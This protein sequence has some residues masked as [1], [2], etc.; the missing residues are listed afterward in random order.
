MGAGSGGGETG[1][2][3]HGRNRVA[4]D[5]LTAADVDEL[6]DYGCGQ[7]N[8][9][10]A[11]ARGFASK[12]HACDID[13]GLIA[14]LNDRFGAEV[15]FFPIPDSAPTL[16]LAEGQVSAI[17][18]CD[19]LEHMPPQIRRDALLEMNRVLAREGILVLTVPHKSLLAAPDP[20]NAKVFF[21]RLHRWVYRVA[22]GRAKYEE[23]YGGD[24]FGNFST[25]AVKHEHF[26]RAEL[27]QLLSGA[28]FRIEEVRY[29]G[30][31]YPLAR[32]LLWLAEALERRLPA[33]RPL[34][35]ALWRLYRWD[36]D[37]EPGRIGCFI[38]VKARKARA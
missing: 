19:V 7:G 13:P 4:F 6:L 29:F 26:S 38:A 3:A 31:I 16:D 36:S 2:F 15:N 30:L 34:T 14:K 21:P 10:V 32:T 24:Q 9:A 37:L 35:A 8:I 28:G 5:L 12:V 27:D 25:G 17:T 23:V 22:R 20:E 1:V 33:S 11:A 18:C